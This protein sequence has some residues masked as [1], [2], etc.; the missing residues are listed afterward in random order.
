[1]SSLKIIIC[2]I[3]YIL[4]G[5]KVLV[6]AAKNIAHGE[7]F[8]ENFLMAIAT[9]AA[10][11]IGDCLEAVGI[12]LFYN[13]GE[14]FED[15]AV[16]RSREQ[17]AEA[18]DMRPEKV[19]LA[20]GHE[21]PAEL[22]K[23]GDILI[24][25]TGDRVPLDGIVASGEGLLDTSPVTGEPAHVKV[26]T[27]EKLISG[28]ISMGGEFTMEVT[29]P[30]SESM[31]TRILESVEQASENKP[32]IE[33][34]I[35]KF[36]KIYTPIVCGLALL[37][38]VL[39]PMILG[40]SWMNWITSAITFLV[41]S[42]P[43][44]MVISVPLAFFLGVGAASRQG[45]L[46]KS[47]QALEALRGIKA[48]ALDKT[49]T[50]TQGA[51]D[52]LK[53]DSVQGVAEI[54]ALGLIP[55]MLTGDKTER[56]EAIA[57]KVGINPRNVQSQLLPDDKLNAMLKLREEHGEILFVGDGINDAP[58]LAGA[59]VGGAMG[60]GTDA[61][62]ESA[63]IVFMNSG[64]SAIPQVLKIAARTG[65]VAKQNIWLALSIKVLV[66]AL[67]FAGLANIWLAVLAD[68]GVAMLCILNSLRLLKN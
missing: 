12:M 27:G 42:C 19:T 68:T 49:G 11:A 45:I 13:I 34:F 38:A 51:N 32:E 20:S 28:C 3:L 44:A 53:P 35:T 17:I 48:V 66:L 24:V 5:R 58:V 7:V 57:A 37:V 43:C 16:D 33:K 46:V 14:R 61:A 31:V 18:I 26:S 63:D 6:K 23:P 15:F 55:A 39:P 50:L 25:A 64:V 59:D 36:A 29:A 65:R 52:E 21:I 62:V 4:L 54:K 67:G 2:V 41:I 47:G 8:D 22:A 10:F 9:L 1:M 40:A 60:S 56:A 30:L